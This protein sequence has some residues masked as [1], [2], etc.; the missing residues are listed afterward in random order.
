[1]LLIVLIACIAVSILGIVL[2]F[3]DLDF[4]LLLT[5]IG[6]AALFILI[7]GTGWNLAIALLIIGCLSFI[8]ALEIPDAFPNG[9]SFWMFIFGIVWATY[10]LV[11]VLYLSC[12][13]EVTL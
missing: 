11:M 8:I 7:F 1:M 5:P 2:F 3:L 4:L 9:V 13:I 12:F 10:G 6:I